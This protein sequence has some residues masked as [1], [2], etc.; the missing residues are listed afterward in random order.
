LIA[1]REAMGRFSR[2]PLQQNTQPQ[3]GNS[4]ESRLGR[5]ADNTDYAA[6]GLAL[7]AALT[8][9]TGVGGAVLGGAAL[10]LKSPH[11]VS[12]Q[13]N[14]VFNSITAIEVAL[15]PLLRA[16]VLVFLRRRAYWV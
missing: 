11:S 13:P 15:S 3:C 9:E 16:L 8:S 5:Y 1:V 2:A 6:K 4:L 10:G 14:S 12:Q 7:G